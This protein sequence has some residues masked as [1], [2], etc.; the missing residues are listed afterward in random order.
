FYRAFESALSSDENVV[1]LKASSDDVY[2]K[3]KSHLFDEENI[4]KYLGRT[5]VRYVEFADRDMI[6]ISL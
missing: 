6:M 2:Q 4:F 3:I 1:Y 5:N